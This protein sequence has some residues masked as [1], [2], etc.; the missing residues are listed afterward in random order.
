MLDA[1]QLGREQG[2]Y[3][4]W[5][6][7]IMP[8]HVHLVLLPRPNVNISQILRTLKQPVSK[9]ALFWLKEHSPDFLAELEHVG[10]NEKRSH[11][12]WQRGGGYDRNLRS[13]S[14]IYEKIEYI[15]ENPVRRGLVES[16]T[17][18]PWSSCLAWE[19]EEGSIVPID[20][21]SLPRLEPTDGRRYRP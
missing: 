14:D 3:D 18:W 19:T 12:F 10:S 15:H 16:A 2:K 7:V 13:V 8:E 17:D 21:E 9:R 4:L 1:I 6:Y 20:K 5:A 11:H